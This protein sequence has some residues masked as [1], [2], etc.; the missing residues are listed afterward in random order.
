[1]ATAAL[2][3]V[4]LILV[5]LATA[6]GRHGASGDGSFYGAKCTHASTWSPA[7]HTEFRANVMALLTR[8]PSAAAPTGFASL[9]G[10]G[11]RGME[12]IEG[13]LQDGQ[14]VAVQR[15]SQLSWQGFQELNNELEFVSKG[16]N[17]SSVA[18]LCN[19]GIPVQ[20]KSI[21]EFGISSIELVWDKWKAGLVAEAVDA[22]LRGQYPHAE[23]L[24]CVQ[25]G[26]L[27]VQEKRA[28]RPNASAVALMLQDSNFTSSRQAPSRPAYF[29]S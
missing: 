25:V 7:N 22:S 8:L 9:R 15:L 3:R 28:L 11:S 23:M 6:V 13:K 12:Y 2:N 20:Y 18:I 4:L 19:D 17:P 29:T 24:N 1:M 21:S 14:V 27:C 26:L 10:E 16:S 5:L